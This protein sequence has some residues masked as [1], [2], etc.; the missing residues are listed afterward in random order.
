MPTKKFLSVVISLTQE[1]SIDM[2][3]CVNRLT[4]KAAT[5]NADLSARRDHD[6]NKNFCRADLIG[7]LIGPILS[8]V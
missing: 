1:T 7:R 3:A 2:L 4:E 8:L 6:A 5:V